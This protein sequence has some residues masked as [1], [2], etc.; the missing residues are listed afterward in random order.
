[1]LL[2]RIGTDLSRDDLV[3]HLQHLGCDM[4]GFATMRRY[5]C[6]KCENLME[7]TETENP[8]V[9]CDRCGSD[10]K[11]SPDLLSEFG[12]TEVIR[13][14]LLPVRP[15]MFDPG[16]LARVLRNYLGE[17]SEPARYELAPPA[18]S[19]RVDPS[20]D[21]EAC[22]RP[23]IACA[24]MHGIELNDD[25]IKV[26][27][28]LQEN[29]HWA[30]G[31]DR[32]HAS[33]GVYDL[34][35]VTTGQFTYRAVG[36]EEL[37][38]APL[39]FDADHKITPARVLEE[40]PK[41]VGYARLLQDFSGYPFLF[42]EQ[43]N[44]LAMIPIIN[45][46]ST[47]VQMGTTSFFI[48]VTG[49]GRRIVDKTLNI[50]VTSLLEL[51]PGATAEQVTMN[52]PDQQV[53]TP[54]LSPQQVDL[55][56]AHTA[57]FIGLDLSPADVEGHLRQMGHG[58]TLR[59][60]GGMDVAVPAYRNDI[61]H[62]VDLVEDVAIAYGYHNVEPRL[63]ATL[64]VGT[65]QPVEV[66]SEAARR[67]MT[68]QGYLEVLTLILSSPEANYDS[69]LLPRREEYVLID[70]PIS[71]EQTMIR[72]TL[73]PGLLE[74]F[75]INTNHEMPQRIFEVGNISLLHELAE[76]GAREVRMAAAGATG[77]RVDYSEIRAACEALLADL[78]WTLRT[79][80]A[81]GAPC[82]IPGR[83]ARVLA[84][85]VDGGEENEVGLMGEVHPQV[86]ENYKLV[87]PAAVFEVDL[88]RL[89]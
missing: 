81:D 74:T 37:T 84:T 22:R 79:V 29:L 57:R 1:M 45:S 41:G 3:L 65:E 26:V 64:T 66:F 17:N 69:L 24:V 19:V 32:K 18:C 15:D 39:G 42:D 61:M 71:V 46:E 88:S 47:R 27:M 75:G 63:V 83:G 51:C 12:S 59:E 10:Y 55:D 60:D 67:A 80:P 49:S 2:K 43:D 31:R 52:Y 20:V 76:T 5:R 72:T 30:L 40:H 89:M 58:V 87:Q 85:P 48:D 6:E 9:L 7:I 35:T 78:G 70:N 33:I 68:G 77:P 73:V 62:P 86:L 56:P 4:E 14:E 8:P 38:F 36:P 16:G 21:T 13:M 23:F 82:F 50:M 25:R 44:V 54:D 53:V 28:K 11:D 34:D